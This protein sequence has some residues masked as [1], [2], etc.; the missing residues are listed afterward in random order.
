MKQIFVWFQSWLFL[1]VLIFV[2]ASFVVLRI[3][4]TNKLAKNITLQ[5]KTR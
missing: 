2:G 1:E 4:I 3:V 5:N